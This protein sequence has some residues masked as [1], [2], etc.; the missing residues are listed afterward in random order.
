VIKVT[1]GITY[2]TEGSSSLVAFGADVKSSQWNIDGLDRTAPEGG[3]LYWSMNEELVAEIQVLGSG[4]TAEY[5]MMLGPAFNVVTKSGTNQFHGVASLDYS[6]A[7]WVSENAVE[8]DAPEGLQTYRLDHDTNLAL[9]LGGPI[10]RDKLWFFAAAEFG[11]F[12]AFDPY[13]SAEQYLK[14][15]SEWQN[16]DLKFTSQ[17]SQNHRLTLVM[18]RH[19]GLWPSPGDVYTEPSATGETWGLDKAMNLDYSGILGPNTVLEARA[20]MW[21]ADDNWRAQYPSD[22][23]WFG[24]YTVIPNVVTGGFWGAY[25]WEIHSD[26]AEILLTQ[27]AD[28]FIKGDHEFKFGVQYNRGGGSSRQGLRDYFY[29]WETYVGYGYDYENYE[30]IYYYEDYTY[31]VNELPVMYGGD[32]ETIGVF[33]QDSWTISPR[34]TLDIGVRYDRHEG[35]IPDFHRL[36]SDSN[37][38][39]ELIPGRDVLNWSNT[40]PRF[41]FA[42]QP[43]ADG[44][45]VLRGSIG[46]FSARIASGDWYQPPPGK[47]SIDYYYQDLDTGEWILFDSEPP[48]PDVSLV[49]GTKN[50]S[51]W[52]YTLGF[53]QQIGA[54]SAIGVQ[55]VYKKTSD[56]LGWYVA[57]D[58][59]FEWYTFT[60]PQSGEVYELMDYYVEPTRYKGNSTGPGSNGGDR[61]YEQEYLGF[62]LTYKKRFANNWDLFASYSYSEGRGLSSRYAYGGTGTSQGSV[63]YDSI[64]ESDPNA[65][66]GYDSDTIL[67]GDRRHILRLVG[68]VMLPYQFKINSVVNIQSG[69]TYSRYEWIRMPS[70]E[71]ARLTTNIAS[72]DQRMPTQY[73]WDFGVGKHFNLGR[74]MEISIYLQI[75]NILND[76]AP[77]SWAGYQYPVGEEP[78]PDDWVLPRRANLRLRF[79]F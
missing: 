72:D 52:E 16:Y 8:E 20:G 6:N 3:N 65:F 22:E 37:P 66:L 21:R 42:W 54:T 32:S 40:D 4:A 15:G 47:G 56:G 31:F 34:L 73:L 68:N 77:E 43:T 17:L 39:D 25:D 14:D 23:P 35:W 69:R 51:T 36:D 5:G 10:V 19:D 2:G 70:R 58:G 26:N 79:S 64:G 44:R 12:L 71:W 78:I 46:R 9:T 55:A 75:L 27:H 18:N 50:A 48:A 28:E 38:T 61:P 57:D 63:F 53:D 49:P 30:Y 11:E 59:E 33:A 60:H 67:A 24:D 41:G 7:D 13:E 29:L 74:G 45:S 62:F 1:P 76:D